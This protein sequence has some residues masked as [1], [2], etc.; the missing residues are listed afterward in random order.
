MAHP[1]TVELLKRLA[2]LSGW[3]IPDDRLEA[4]AA[5]Y[6][7]IAEDTRLLRQADLQAFI[8]ST[9]FDPK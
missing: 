4:M 6:E 1:D 8:P 5:V 2:A 9:V 3:T 7:S